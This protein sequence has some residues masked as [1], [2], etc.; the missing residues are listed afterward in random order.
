TDEQ[1]RIDAG[2][3][4]SIAF[5]NRGF[6]KDYK[7]GVFE[8]LT[9]GELENIG[10][11]DSNKGLEITKI[12]NNKKPAT[13]DTANR[14]RIVTTIESKPYYMP[15]RQTDESGDLYEGYAADLA[16]EVANDLKFQYKI[17]LVKDMKYGERMADGTWNGMVGELTRKEADLAIAPLT[18]TSIR[19]RVIDFS[20]PFMS[21]GISI[22][23]KKPEKQKPG[24]FSF[25]EPLSQSIWYCIVISYLGVSLVLF[26]VSRFSPNEWQIE[27]TSYQGGLSFTNDF[28]LLNSLW[29]SLG[30]FMRRGCDVCP[31][32]LSGR[33]VGSAW[34]FFTLI[35]ISSYTANLAA[36]LTVSS[37]GEAV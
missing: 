26:L 29:F 34:W 10:V 3:T 2:L 14:T 23:I 1:T 6:R 33:I 25:M 31:R 15:K 35:I 36:F 22:M 18:I 11:W 28:T 19:E 7:L 17:Q 5:D 21:L 32:S 13:N 4:G 37:F 20:K 27:E 30:A 24:V 12:T 8:M 16:Q 9:D